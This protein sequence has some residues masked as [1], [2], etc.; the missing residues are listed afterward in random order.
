MRN[1]W[2]TFGFDHRH[3]ETGES[4]S[5][6]YVVIQAESSEEAR[7]KMFERFG[8]KWAMQYNS[9]DSAGVKK[10]NLKEIK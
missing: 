5:G 1:Y 9:A 10:W 2:F 8:N 6:C 3:P 4:L 7:A